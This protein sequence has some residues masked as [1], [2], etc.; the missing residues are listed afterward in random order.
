LANVLSRVVAELPTDLEEI[1]LVRFGLIARRFS[2]LGLVHRLGREMRK[3]ATQAIASKAG[4]L[5]SEPFQMGWR[6]IGALQYWTSFESLDIWSHAPLHAG[7]WRAAVDRMRNK[8]D[9]GVYHEAFLI[10]RGEFESIYL[11]CPPVG[12]GVFGTLTE[13]VGPKTT[14]KQRLNR[15]PSGTKE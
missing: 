11:D 10:K 3:S 2:S 4:L 15:R 12:L 7:W 1:C 9:L 14:A 13:P 6:H 8:G 5:V